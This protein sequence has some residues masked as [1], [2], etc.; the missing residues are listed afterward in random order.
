[1]TDET[2]QVVIPEVPAAEGA[3]KEPEQENKG[4]PAT[5]WT[6]EAAEAE[7]K[8]LR[9]EA[10]KYRKERQAEVKAR[11]AAEAAALEEQGKY[12]ELYEKATPKLSEYDTLKERYD[13]ILAAV[14]ETNAKRIGAIPEG[15][16]SLVPEYDDPLKTAAWLDANAAVFTRPQPPSLDGRAGGNGSGTPSVD[17]AAIKARAVRLGL[18]PELYYQNALKSAK[19]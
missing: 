8:A 13:A 16:R 5:V 9:A 19:R 6:Q 3:Q 18:D 12:K 17:E 10:A 11:E 14:Q 1:M 15:M 7:I 4:T 2:T